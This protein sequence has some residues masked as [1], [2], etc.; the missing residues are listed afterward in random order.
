LR[1]PH[2]A[3]FQGLLVCLYYISLALCVYSFE[4]LFLSSF[5]VAA[6][7]ASVHHHRPIRAYI[8]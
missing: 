7:G 4:I 6:R 5:V 8:S 1:Q 3:R 2:R